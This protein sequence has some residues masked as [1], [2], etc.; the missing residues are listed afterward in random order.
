MILLLSHVRPNVRPCGHEIFSCPYFLVLIFN[1]RTI[2]CPMLQ[3]LS[4]LTMFC[5]HNFSLICRFI[6][7]F[8]QSYINID[9]GIQTTSNIDSAILY[10]HCEMK[11]QAVERSHIYHIFTPIKNNFSFLF[12]IVLYTL[13]Q[14]TYNPCTHGCIHTNFNTKWLLLFKKMTSKE[15]ACRTRKCYVQ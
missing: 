9:R 15:N 4:F 6:L 3:P 2:S 7:Q 1:V 14:N 11:T 10:S 13:M 8:S 12:H 5:N